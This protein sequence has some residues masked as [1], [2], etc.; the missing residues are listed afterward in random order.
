[1]TAC[2]SPH[3]FSNI[4]SLSER[5]TFRE[6]PKDLRSH[7]FFQKKKKTSQQHTYI[8]LSFLF[9][10]PFFAG[11]NIIFHSNDLSRSARLYD[12]IQ[13]CLSTHNNNSKFSWSFRSK[14][15]THKQQYKRN[16]FFL[17]GCF[18]FPV[19]ECSVKAHCISFFGFLQRKHTQQRGT[20]SK[21]PNQSNRLVLKFQTFSKH[22]LVIPPA[23]KGLWCF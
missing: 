5:N 2:L 22:R 4:V 21:Y 12:F 6:H 9:I 8:P 20:I 17:V 10:P 11:R 14:Q 16:N 15:S 7:T 13:S 3:S 23:R 1:M 18:H 19:Y